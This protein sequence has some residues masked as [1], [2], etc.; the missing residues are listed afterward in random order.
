MLGWCPPAN[1]STGTASARTDSHRVADP[2]SGAQPPGTAGDMPWAVELM[3]PTSSVHPH[4]WSR[5]SWCD[6]A[7]CGGRGRAPACS[8]PPLRPAARK[9]RNRSSRRAPTC[10]H[11]ASFEPARPGRSR[12]PTPRPNTT[13]LSTLPAYIPSSRLLF[14]SHAGVR[15]CECNIQVR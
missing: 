4:E 12:R 2:T 5:R 3:P 11:D 1:P 14:S 6:A 9:V 15:R 10:R 13:V 8:V 7:S